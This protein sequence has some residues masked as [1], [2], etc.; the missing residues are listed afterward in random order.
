MSQ[1]AS[2]FFGFS[3][4]GFDFF[5]FFC[6]PIP[7]NCVPRIPR[8]LAKTLAIDWGGAES[9]PA[10]QLYSLPCRNC[11]SVLRSWNSLKQHRRE[12]RIT[13]HIDSQATIQALMGDIVKIKRVMKT[14]EAMHELGSSNQVWLSCNNNNFNQIANSHYFWQIVEIDT[15]YASTYSGID[16]PREREKLMI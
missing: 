1:G 5:K 14:M 10:R 8:N 12:D 11:C 13:F 6:L 15:C 2:L 4:L 7:P 3:S 16:L 9:P